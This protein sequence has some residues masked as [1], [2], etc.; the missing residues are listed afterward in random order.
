VRSQEPPQSAWNG[1]VNK[2]DVLQVG[3]RK[4]G[5]HGGLEERE[6]EGVIGKEV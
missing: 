3:R 6:G 1:S 5:Y 4:K 2:N